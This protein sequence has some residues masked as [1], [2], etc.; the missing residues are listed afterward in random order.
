MR[1]RS[2]KRHLAFSLVELVVVI[3]II[4][5]IAAMAIPR[6][7]RGTAGAGD[8]AAAGNLAIMRNAIRM[9]YAEHNSTYPTEAKFTEQLTMYTSSAGAESASRDGT[10]PYGPYLVAIPPCPVGDQTDPTAIAFYTSGA[11]PDPP[12]SA[13]TG[14]WIYNTTTGEIIAN[15]NATDQRGKAYYKY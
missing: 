5:I 1:L 7:S 13:D 3:V 14:G 6:F 12:V 9:Y 2:S 15:T 4:G 8:S 11:F 10:H